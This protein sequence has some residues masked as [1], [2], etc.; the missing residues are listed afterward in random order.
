MNVT[1]EETAEVRALDLKDFPDA[2][3]IQ[4][5]AP[6]AQVLVNLPP[7]GAS[8][9]GAVLQAT[10]EKT[11]N[12]QQGGDISRI[13]VKLSTPGDPLVTAKWHVVRR[14]GALAIRVDL[15]SSLQP[16]PSLTLS[17]NSQ[18]AETSEATPNC[19]LWVILERNQVR[20]AQVHPSSPP[21]SSAAS[22]NGDDV[23][24]VQ[25]VQVING[26]SRTGPPG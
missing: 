22:R 26:R 4:D 21:D 25:V 7:G 1:G 20:D 5:D 13:R 2:D 9:G 17:D 3:D 10:P 18:A 8:R 15:E 12:I 6:T 24:D 16:L 19:I 23:E 11:I 14:G